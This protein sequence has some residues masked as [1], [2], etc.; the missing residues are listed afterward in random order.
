MSEG[1]W[2]G[3]AWPQSKPTRH[4]E[5]SID[6]QTVVYKIDLNNFDSNCLNNCTKYEY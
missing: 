3:V 1:R 2:G 5:C 4:S 6:I